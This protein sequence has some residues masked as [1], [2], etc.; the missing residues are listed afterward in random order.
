VTIDALGRTDVDSI[1]DEAVDALTEVY[2]AF[3]RDE[4][5]GGGPGASSATD[6]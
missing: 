1:S 4:T 2:R 3:L 5:G 6:A